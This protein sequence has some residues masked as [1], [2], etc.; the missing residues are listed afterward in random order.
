MDQVPANGIVRQKFDP[1]PEN[2]D[3][4]WLHSAGAGG[5]QLRVGQP[6]GSSEA[7]VT[8]EPKFKQEFKVE[9]YEAMPNDPAVPSGKA[10]ARLSFTEVGLLEND[11]A[12]I[13][14]E[15]EES[16]RAAAL[17]LLNAQTVEALAFRV[18]VTKWDGSLLARC[19]VTPQTLAHLEGTIHAVLMTPD[20][21]PAGVFKAEFLV[22]AALNHATNCLSHLQRKRWAPN[23]PTLDIGHRGSGAS[24]VN[25]HSV[26]ENTVL[27]FQKAAI[28]HSDF[29]EFDVHVTSDGEVVVHHD[30]Q[31]ALSL[32]SE[33]L[34]VGIPSLT[35][36]QLASPDFTRWMVQPSEDM[37][38]A[39]MDVERAKRRSGLRRNMSSGEDMLRSVLKPSTLSP[40][41]AKTLAASPSGRTFVT[42]GSAPQRWYLQD[43]IAS[44]RDAFKNTPSWLG[45]NIELKYPTRFEVAAMRTHFYSRNHFVDAVLRVVLDE[46]KGRKI[47][48]STFDPDCATLLSLKQPR[49]PVFF[50]TC[51]GTK[52]FEDPRMNS[53]DAAL[54]FA[55]SSK[56]QGVVAEATAVL[57]RLNETVKEFHNHGLFLFTW[58]DVNNDIAHYTAQR[59]AGVDAIIMDDVARI[60]RATNKQF[61]MF[62]RKPVRVPSSIQDLHVLEDRQIEVGLQRLSSNLNIMTMGPI[63]SPRAS[64]SSLFPPLRSPPTQFNC[65]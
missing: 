1:R 64:T 11:P 34:K 59:E 27:S 5:F 52:T 65:Y 4:G 8:L 56:L 16:E 47:I 3:S 51:G 33:L 20:L 36:E 24:K 54:N 15:G 42:A 30:F 49:Y 19:F 50:L 46:A 63:E 53:L 28:N 57:S 13:F 31:V 58:G 22:V 61:S 55:L 40:E 48:F 60:A 37:G 9:L 18:D 43:K 10:F 2:S 41:T 32:G 26:R 21:E 38:K 17:F 39:A 35:L 12:T 23:V 6:P 62:A 25:G 29:I 7:L 45:F 44:L 14:E